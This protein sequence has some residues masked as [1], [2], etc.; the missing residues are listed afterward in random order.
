MWVC[1]GVCVCVCV[2]VCICMTVCV[3]NCLC[4]GLCMHV[5]QMYP[6]C[7]L[8]SSLVI[9]AVSDEIEFLSQIHTQQASKEKTK[10]DSKGLS[11]CCLFVWCVCVCVFEH[12]RILFCFSK[13]DCMKGGGGLPVDM[14]M[15]F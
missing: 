5:C 13:R 11:E 14:I 12:L 9:F 2:C 6:V 3:F 4:P 10:R 1:V 7:L 15:S 8:K